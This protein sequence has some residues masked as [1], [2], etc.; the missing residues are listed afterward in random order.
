MITGMAHRSAA[1][2]SL[3]SSA[4]STHAMARLR[5]LLT[6]VHE[7]EPRANVRQLDGRSRP[8]R[9]DAINRLLLVEG[10]PP[11]GSL[12]PANSGYLLGHSDQ[13]IERLQLQARCLEGLTRRLIN[14][15]GVKPGM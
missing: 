5:S 13:E 14:E 3:F 1:R 10:D 11:A 4:R 15:C 12:M 6:R 9:V 7:R 2:P 8:G